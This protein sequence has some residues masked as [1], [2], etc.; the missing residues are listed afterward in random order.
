MNPYEELL[1]TQ[2]TNY[3]TDIVAVRRLLSAVLHRACIDYA[4]AR[5]AGDVRRYL[6]MKEW[7]SQEVPLAGRK[8]RLSFPWIC[9]CLELDPGQFRTKLFD[10]WKVVARTNLATIDRR[11]IRRGDDE[12]FDEETSLSESV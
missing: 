5:A 10:E 1:W 2:G 4:N 8:H 7:F 6:Y 3:P 12:F 11:A 9:E